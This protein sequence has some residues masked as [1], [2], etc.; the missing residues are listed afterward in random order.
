[1]TE[2]EWSPAPPSAPFAPWFSRA[3]LVAAYL[4][5]FGLVVLGSVLGILWH[6]WSNTPT[7]GLVYTAHSIV[8]DETEGFVSS[9]G[10]FAVLTTVLGLLAGLL[11]WLWRSRRGWL[12]IAGLTIGAVAGSIATDLV[13]H[14][15][16]GGRS[17][18]TVNTVLPRLPL[19]VHAYGLLFLEGAAAL[20]VYLICA[21]SASADDLGTGEQVTIVFPPPLPPGAWPAPGG[22]HA[23]S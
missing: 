13:G 23:I 20:A 18:G 2:P 14:L 7:R 5:V 15:L 1:M 12:M 21:L 19:Q 4:A 9:D 11:A 10:R 6:F 17:S 3:E 16:G 22:G 8:P